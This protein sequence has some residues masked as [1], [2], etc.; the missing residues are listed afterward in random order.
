MAALIASSPEYFERFRHMTRGEQIQAVAECLNC[1]AWLPTAR[2]ALT[3]QD[4][5]LDHVEQDFLVPPA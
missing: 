5:Q 4:A 2:D 3:H 1:G